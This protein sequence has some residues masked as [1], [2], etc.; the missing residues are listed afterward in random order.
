MTLAAAPVVEVATFGLSAGAVFGLLALGLV[1]IYRTTGV[2]NFA[3]WAVGLLAVVTYV[4]LTGLGLPPLVAVVP[5]MALGVGG[6]VLAYRLVFRRISGT[7]Q[8][9]VILISIGIA[10]F[11]SS[12]AAFVLG[13]EQFTRLEPWLPVRDWRVLG[14]NVRSSTPT[15]TNGCA[16]WLDV[17]MSTM[18]CVTTTSEPTW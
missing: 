12:L 1:L 17:P 5:S 7:A 4:F 9:I 16:S 11:F 13:F 14:V 15:T 6:G 18:P 3:H 8:I 2:M 10:Q